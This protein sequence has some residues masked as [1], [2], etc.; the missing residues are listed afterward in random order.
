[1][2][3]IP[4]GMRKK[5]NGLFEK[6]FTVDGKRYSAYGH[7]VKECAENEARIREEIKAGLYNSNKNITLDA[8]FEEWEKSRIGVIKDSSLKINRSKYNNHIKPVLGKT[9]IQKIEKREVV[10]LQQDLSKKLSASMTNGVIVVLKTVLNAA[11]D[12]EIIVKNPAASVKPLRMDDRPKASETIHRALTREE[13][14]AFIQEAKQEWLYEF[15]CF[16]LC[17]GMR[18]NEIVALK[19]QDIDYIN[20]VIHVTKTVSWKQG[21]GIT[22]TSPK[23]ETSK[24]DIPMNDTIKKVLHMQRKKMAMIYGEIVARKMDSN[25]FI[26]SNGSRAV[27]SSTVAFSINN[28]L[29]RLR[30]QGIEI[31][32]FTHHAFRDTFATR[33]I[34]E[35]GNMQTL[36]KILGH[37]SL[38][39]TADLYAHVL[40]STKQQEMKQ[41]ENGFIGVAVL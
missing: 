39:M 28:V 31:E 25:I 29:K 7:N 4:S 12:D 20:N 13:Q 38:A 27:A 8:Y 21:G 37:S 18:L 36:Q 5:E 11:I 22:E 34:E 35:G 6:R 10:K 1:M 2:A 3:R 32:R 41:V 26:G 23:S 9:K 17:T 33:Y 16:S 24:R 14:Q 40:P 30:Q 15:F 19:W